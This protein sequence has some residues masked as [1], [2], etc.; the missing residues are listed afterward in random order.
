MK[1]FNFLKSTFCLCV[2]FSVSTNMSYAQNTFPS[3]GKV[4]IGT[5]S[6]VEQLQIE[7]G[8]DVNGSTGGYVVLGS[9]SGRNMGIDNNEIQSR[10][11]GNPV[12]LYIQHAGSNLILAG[13]GGNVG[14][15][16][17]NPKNEL[18]VCGTIRGKEVLVED[19]WCD[20]VF[21]EDYDL[22][23]LEEEKAHI[24]TAGYL[25][26]FESEE[27]MGGE[28]NVGDVTKRQQQKIEEQMLHIIDLNELVK[29]LVKEVETLKSQIQK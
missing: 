28:I 23:T 14:V 22:P 13:G 29:G 5:N 12:P 24:E 25:L 16:V 15:G 19:T 18:D 4:G 21:Y 1:L 17:T 10:N 27:E 26:G 20:F 11:N 3:T 9:L 8:T 6:P 7:G 2:L